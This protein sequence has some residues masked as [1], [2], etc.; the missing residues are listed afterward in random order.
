MEKALKMSV[1]L[2]KQSL[3]E[4]FFLQRQLPSDESPPPTVV[5]RFHRASPH[6]KAA[7]VGTPH[8]APWQEWDKAL[9]R[10]IKCCSATPANFPT[11][12]WAGSPDYHRVVAPRRDLPVVLLFQTLKHSFQFAVTL[13][14]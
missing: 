9:P 8:A 3:A 11:D 12:R 1:R 13:I 5:V 14:E 10:S 2:S 4:R 6:R 7:I